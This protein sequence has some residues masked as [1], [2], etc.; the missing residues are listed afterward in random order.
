MFKEQATILIVDDNP[1][2]LSIL[3]ERIEQRDHK[4]LTAVN[5]RQA[6]AILQKKLFIWSY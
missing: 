3:Q 4:T 2:L 6:L 1:D 5:G